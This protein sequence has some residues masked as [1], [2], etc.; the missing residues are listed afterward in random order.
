MEITPP[1]LSI[2]ALN[3]ATSSAEKVHHGPLL[4]SSDSEAKMITL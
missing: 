1:P 3:A 2:H 4:E